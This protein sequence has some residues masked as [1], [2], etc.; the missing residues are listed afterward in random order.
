[1]TV[2]T[3]VIHSRGW[4]IEYTRTQGLNDDTYWVH[5]TEHPWGEGDV[6][7][8]GDSRIEALMDAGLTEEEAEAAVDEGCAF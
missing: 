1:M 3:L 5:S 7:G 4:C 2:S 8:V 6:I